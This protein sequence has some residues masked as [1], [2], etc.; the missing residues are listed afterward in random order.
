MGFMGCVTVHQA[1][2]RRATEVAASVE[3]RIVGA[4]AGEFVV[5]VR[6]EGASGRATLL[7]DPDWVGLAQEAQALDPALVADMDVPDGAI[8]GFH[9]GW[10]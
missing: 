8:V 3:P 7:L 5:V 1:S 6:L 2:V 10:I 4:L 9:D